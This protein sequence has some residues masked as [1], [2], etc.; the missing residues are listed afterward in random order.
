MWEAFSNAHHG[1]FLELNTLH[2][3]VHVCSFKLVWTCVFVK[4]I[5]NCRKM[6]WLC[7][8]GVGKITG[9]STLKI[10]IRVLC[11]QIGTGLQ[12]KLQS[13]LHSVMQN[14]SSTHPF[15]NR[16]SSLIR[17]LLDIKQSPIDSL[18]CLLS[19]KY[20]YKDSYLA[21]IFK[22]LFLLQLDRFYPSLDICC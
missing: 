11:G 6:V 20:I 19:K 17:T 13:L 10:I 1:G 4:V 18:T 16:Y 14:F 2:L 22:I 5:T 7:V 21:Q 12:F 15:S 8:S 3:N 9:K